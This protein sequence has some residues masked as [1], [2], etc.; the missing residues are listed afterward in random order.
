M[1]RAGMLAKRGNSFCCRG[2][3]WD[4]VDGIE[5]ALSFCGCLYR[6]ED[7]FGFVRLRQQ[8]NV[9]ERLRC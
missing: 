9:G 1:V 2:A 7:N 5:N 3:C 6:S 8:H 4:P